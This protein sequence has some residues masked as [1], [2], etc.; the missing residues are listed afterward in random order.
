MF[1]ELTARSAEHLKHWA[2][3]AAIWWSDTRHTLYVLCL[4]THSQQKSILRYE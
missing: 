4:R 3:S 1:S 2:D